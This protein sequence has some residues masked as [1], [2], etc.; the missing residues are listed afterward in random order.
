MPVTYADV[1]EFWLRHRELASAVD[2]VTVHILPYWEDDPIAA[3]RG[4][5]PCRL[6]PQARGRGRFPARRS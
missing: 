6:D 3:T 5:E 2:F 4:R 1:W